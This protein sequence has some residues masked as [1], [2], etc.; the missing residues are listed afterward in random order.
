[1]HFLQVFLIV[2]ACVTTVFVQGGSQGGALHSRNVTVRKQIE[3]DRTYYI[4]CVEMDWDYAPNATNPFTGI[5]ATEELSHARASGKQ[6]L[7][8]FQKI[9]VY[10][11]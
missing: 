3:A 11:V 9:S 4:A 6:C 10:F 1:M 5:K 8:T 2:V 7:P